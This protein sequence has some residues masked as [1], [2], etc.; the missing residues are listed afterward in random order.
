MKNSEKSKCSDGRYRTPQFGAAVG[1]VG[2]SAVRALR[3][4]DDDLSLFVQA[5]P[6]TASP[7]TRFRRGRWNEKC[8]RDHRRD[9]VASMGVLRV[10]AGAPA[11]PPKIVYFRIYYAPFTRSDLKKSDLLPP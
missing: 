10:G 9:D 11:P 7:T 3:S 8:Q 6:S 4:R 1:R 2:R 5:W